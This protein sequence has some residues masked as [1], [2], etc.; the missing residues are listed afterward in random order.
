[1]SSHEII[2]L[3]TEAGKKDDKLNTVL[4]WIA[5]ALANPSIDTKFRIALESVRDDILLPAYLRQ[6]SMQKIV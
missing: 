1:V 3:L 4:D 6:L 5:K 2:R